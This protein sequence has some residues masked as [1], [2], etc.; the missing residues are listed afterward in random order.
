MFPLHVIRQRSVSPII[1][2]PNT[3]PLSCPSPTFLHIFAVPLIKDDNFVAMVMQHTSSA[4][5]SRC[6]NVSLEPSMFPVWHNMMCL[7][8]AHALSLWIEK[9]LGCVRG[10]HDPGPAAGGNQQP[11]YC[12]ML[13][14]SLEW[15]VCHCIME[16]QWNNTRNCKKKKK[17]EVSL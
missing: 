1:L 8:R 4:V 14:K 16:V 13:I 3:H 2:P 12:L 11:C 9:R 6:R 10:C 7:L 15:Q 5:L 17:T